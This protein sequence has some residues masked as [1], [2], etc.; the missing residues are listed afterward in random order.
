MDIP[1]PR[2]GLER[3]KTAREALDM[4]TGLLEEL[5]QGGNCSETSQFSYHGSFIIADPTEAWVLETAGKLWAAERIT[6]KWW[7]GFEQL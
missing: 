3:G 4:M 2:L 7:E 6:S 1:V 5:G